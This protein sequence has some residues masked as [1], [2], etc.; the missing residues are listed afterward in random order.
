MYHIFVV[1]IIFL[2]LMKK[3]FFGR[4]DGKELFKKKSD[5]KKGF[6]F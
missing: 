4:L 6:T 3:I 2:L 1:I 5:S